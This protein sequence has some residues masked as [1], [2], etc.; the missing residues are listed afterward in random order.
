MHYFLSE[1]IFKI[2]IAIEFGP[3]L[4]HLRGGNLVVQSHYHKR[5][6]AFVVHAH[7][8]LVQRPRHFTFDAMR[9]RGF[10]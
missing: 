8:Y 4:G 5:R 9:Q 3:G 1:L 2:S 6:E 10:W 7:Q